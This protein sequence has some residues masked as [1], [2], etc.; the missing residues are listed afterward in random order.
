MK[1][2]ICLFGGIILGAIFTSYSFREQKTPSIEVPRPYVGITVKHLR[3]KE[4]VEQI[5][6]RNSESMVWYPC[7]DHVWVRVVE[8]GPEAPF[9][10]FWQGESP[11]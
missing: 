2:L 7:G 8:T 6:K 10:Q 11:E 5:T 1:Y 4:I 3:A 9:L